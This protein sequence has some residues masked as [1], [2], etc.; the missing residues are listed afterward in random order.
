[1]SVLEIDLTASRAHL[2]WSLNQLHH[3]DQGHQE[4]GCHDP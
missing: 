4:V 3:F 1:M 2:H